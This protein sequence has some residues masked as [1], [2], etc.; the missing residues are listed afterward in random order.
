MGQARLG[1]VSGA[2]AIA[3]YVAGVLT[4]GTRPD[5]DA[6][7]GEVAA[8]LD[9]H[10]RRVQIGSAFFALT[11]PFLLWFLAIVGDTA[12]D[13]I[14]RRAGTVALSC[15][16]VF[17]ILFLADVTTLAA[18]ALRPAQ[19]AAEPELASVLRDFEFMAMGMA[20]P[21][22][23]GMLCAL[24]ALALREPA[25]WPRWLALGAFVAAG[26]YMLR[27]ATLFT[28]EGVLAADGA[29]G[30]YLPVAALTAWVLAASATLARRGTR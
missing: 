11:A 2:A 3:L 28:T 5:F 19:V 10:R 8:F 22:V 1:A 9:E 23:T 25:L 27:L 7:P 17:V 6:G 29:L 15:G 20:A 13:A 4:I 14:G 26:L 24:G 21:A 18:A 12:R 16:L 30:L